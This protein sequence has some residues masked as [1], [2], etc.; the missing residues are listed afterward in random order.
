[1]SIWMKIIYVNFPLKWRDYHFIPIPNVQMIEFSVHYFSSKPWGKGN[2]KGNNKKPYFETIKVRNNLFTKKWAKVRILN[3]SS[4]SF[5][6]ANL[7]FWNFQT[8]QRSHRITQNSWWKCFE[9]FEKSRKKGKQTP[10]C[11]LGKNNEN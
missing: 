11:I 9:W 10:I 2:E 7:L 6:F 1:M 5:F 4:P 3:C 8:H